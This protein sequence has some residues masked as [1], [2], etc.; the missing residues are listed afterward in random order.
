MDSTVLLQLVLVLHGSLIVLVAGKSIPQL[1]D[2]DVNRYESSEENDQQDVKVPFKLEETYGV[3]F[4]ANTFNGTWRTDTKILYSDSIL[5]D[6]LLFDAATGTTSSLLDFSVIADFNKPSVSFS[7]DNSFVVIGH[8]Y[9]SGFRYS[10]YQRCV[11]YNTKTNS[12]MEIANGDRIPLIKWSPTRN[13]LI[14][15]HENDIYYQVFS[16]R[17]SIRR[18]TDTGVLDT[19]YNGVPDWVY[20]EEVLASASAA[21]FSPDGRHL[22]F[23]TFNDT[24]VREIGMLRYGIPGNIKYQYPEELKIKYPKTGSPNP[25]VSMTIVDLDN[26]FKLINLEP[27]I[28]VV[29]WDYVLYTVRWRNNYQVAVTWTNR[30]QNKAQIVLYDTKGNSSNIYYEEESEGWLRILPPIFYNEYVIIVK[31]QDSGTS[32]GRFQHAVRFKYTAGKLIDETDLTAGAKEVISILAVDHVRGRLYY[33][34]NEFGAPS[35]RNL[36]SVQLNGNQKP[37]CLSCNV[38]SPERKRCTYA[39]A[40]F[41]TDCSYYALSCSGPDPVFVTIRNA[42]HRKVYNW[43]ENRSLRRKVA[44]RTQPTYKNLQV[45][46]NGY[47]CNVKL[48]LPPD[49]DEKKRYPL[50]INVY[51][52]PNT[53]RITDEAS[54]GFESYMVTNRSVI[55]GRIDGRG[56]AYKGSKMLF[57]IYRRLGTV[58]IEDQIAVTRL[59]QETYP[60]IDSSKTGIWGWSYG[61]FSTAMVLAT[62]RKSVFKCGISVAPVTSWIYYDSLYTE[63]FMGLPTPEDNLHGYNHSDVTRLVE[64]IRGKKFM[65]I[66]GT[67]DDNVHY[68][69]AMALNRALVDKDIMF[70]QQS[71]TDEAHALSGVFPHLYHTMD[72][73]WANCLGY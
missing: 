71:Y 18:I 27:P 64:G 25:V 67:G 43:E 10:V 30:V 40:Y 14:Y 12:Y 49:F 37:V 28:D 45:P 13:A 33:L 24:N 68:Q 57:E 52:G 7:F 44:A 26:P 23:A 50:L 58:E 35:Q 53:V 63:R 1:I 17:S 2:K 4:R 61:G 62:D 70:E 6:T 36:Y 46:M 65:L 47:K 3:N 16:D 39:Y 54:F 21:W 60:W 31:L 42:D 5:G 48:S 56:S 11:V 69:Q 55:Y 34:G 41:S 29:G 73:F 9:E 59:L 15:V 32:A 8:D 51:A 20:E 22:A 38:V 72:R 19:V 66:H